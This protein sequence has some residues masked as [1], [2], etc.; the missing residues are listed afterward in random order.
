MG[1]A[2]A[3]VVA[4][5]VE[6]GGGVVV[7]GFDVCA[8]HI[9]HRQGAPHVEAVVA[10]AEDFK[11]AVKVRVVGQD[12]AVAQRALKGAFLVGDFTNR[13]GLLVPVVTFAE[14]FV[15][16]DLVVVVS[17]T[18]EV[19]VSVLVE[20]GRPHGLGVVGMS[21]HDDLASKGTA[22]EVGNVFDAVAVV[23]GHDEVLVPVSGE[24]CGDEFNGAAEA[25]AD[26][27]G[28]AKGAASFVGEE[29][30]L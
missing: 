1:A 8:A 12:T 22:A 24:V 7:A 23:V 9:A 15:P 20:V 11:G 25:G 19:E 27:H 14:V 18:Q 2:V 3:L 6:L 26:G 21:A 4:A 17:G 16:E 10:A 28:G 29:L 5:E 13:E 30:E